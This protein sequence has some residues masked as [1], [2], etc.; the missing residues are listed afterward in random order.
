MDKMI[1]AISEAVHD[2]WMKAKRAKGVE[3]RRLDTTG[4]ELL[5]PYPALSEEAKDLDRGTVRA[6]IEAAALA[7]FV[8]VPG[9]V[10]QVPAEEFDNLRGMYSAAQSR[11]AEREMTGLHTF[12]W[13]IKQMQNGA[14]VQREGWNGKGMHLYLEEILSHFIGAGV[15]SGATRRYEPCIVMFTAQGKHQPGWLASQADMLAVDWRIATPLPATLPTY[16]S[17]EGA[18][19]GVE[20]HGGAGPGGCGMDPGTPFTVSP[21]TKL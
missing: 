14:L 9:G 17:W 13:A 20:T 19:A 2:A 21:S 12:G 7:G 11:E 5:V 8:F 6:V 18:P 10:G 4:E 1:E 16:P 15:A 3:S